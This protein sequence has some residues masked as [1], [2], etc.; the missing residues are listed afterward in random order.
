MRS[1]SK[2]KTIDI[3]QGD[4]NKQ[5]RYTQNWHITICGPLGNNKLPPIHG[6]VLLID[7]VKKLTFDDFCYLLKKLYNEVQVKEAKDRLLLRFSITFNNFDSVTDEK[8]TERFWLN[9]SQIFSYDDIHYLLTVSYNNTDQYKKLRC[10][11]L[12][13]A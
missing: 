9:C 3:N 10:R 12:A 4:I 5:L 1:P 11:L 7:D 6:P 8:K 2:I 13:L